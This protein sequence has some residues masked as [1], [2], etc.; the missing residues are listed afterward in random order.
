MCPAVF[1]LLAGLGSEHNHRT[2]IPMTLPLP[3]G[4][5]VVLG[6]FSPEPHNGPV[7]LRFLDAA[8]LDDVQLVAHSRKEEVGVIPFFK[9][10]LCA[11]LCNG[12]S[13]PVADFLDS[14]GIGQ[15]A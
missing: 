10:V 12:M 5:Y 2:D 15:S 8:N 4:Y 9:A 1:L 13:R 3:L 6:P 11:L 14:V 7:I